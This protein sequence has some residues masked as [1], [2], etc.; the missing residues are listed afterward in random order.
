MRRAGKALAPSEIQAVTRLAIAGALC[1]EATWDDS[2]GTVHHVGDTVDVA[3]LALAAKLRLDHTKLQ[4][5]HAAVAS[6]PFEMPDRAIGRVAK[7]IQ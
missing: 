4:Q 1:N 7:I 6:I 3:F 2:G 5:E